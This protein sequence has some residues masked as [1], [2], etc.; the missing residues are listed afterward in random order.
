[1]NLDE[2]QT[3]W[4]EYDRKLD[5]LVQLNRKLF[6][7]GTFAQARSALRRQ[8]LWAI[9]GI[10]TNALVIPF[11][12]LFMAL[13]HGSPKY[14]LPAAAIDLYFIANLVVHARQVRLL[15]GL[16][17]TGPVAAIQRRIDQLVRLRIRFAQWLAMTVVLIWVPIS[18]MVAK[19]FLAWDL[20][21]VAPRWL[22][23]NAAAG[24]CCIPIVLWFAR[25]VA[26]GKMA[27]PSQW[28]LREIAGENLGA[29]K[30][31]LDA[32]SDLERQ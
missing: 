21:V 9:L 4:N 7:A 32:L 6:D 24:L 12:G 11:V 18:I 29:A 30:T 15:S 22:L 2:L 31:F 13:N 14:L 5:A 27:R 26:R 3:R 10:I 17:Y 19:A 20:Y 28:L 16:D 8:R 23:A 1:M 25:R